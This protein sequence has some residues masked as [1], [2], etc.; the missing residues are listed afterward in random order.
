VIVV[1]DVVPE[2]QTNYYILWRSKLPNQPELPD[3]PYFFGL[4]IL[5]LI[6]ALAFVM[7]LNPGPFCLAC[8]IWMPFNLVDPTPDLLVMA[9]FL[10]AIPA[11]CCRFFLIFADLTGSVLAKQVLGLATIRPFLGPDV[12][13]NPLV[14]APPFFLL[15][16]WLT[17]S[18]MA[19]WSGCDSISVSTS[20]AMIFSDAISCGTIMALDIV[21]S[22]LN[23]AKS[24]VIFIR[25]FIDLTPYTLHLT[26]YT[27]L[28]NTLTPNLTVLTPDP[29]HYNILLQGATLCTRSTLAGRMC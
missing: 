19:E 28:T 5:D 24:S 8:L 18:V 27:H 14:G 17:P 20:S 4:T 7:A 2:D 6:G 23:G 29:Y 16:I 10:P 25:V 9:I 21:S 22:N 13:L 26:P 11:F 3:R 1:L 15:K 12:H